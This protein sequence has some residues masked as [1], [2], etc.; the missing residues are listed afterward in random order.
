MA[1]HILVKGERER[2]RERE[3]EKKRGGVHQDS[4]MY[5]TFPPE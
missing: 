4:Q 1:E 5:K 2:E 3:R